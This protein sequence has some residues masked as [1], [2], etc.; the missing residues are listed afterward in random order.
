MKKLIASAL[1]AAFS[2]CAA[3]Q[4]TTVPAHITQVSTGWGYDSFSV[5]LS[6]P[7][8]N[9]AGCPLTDSASVS[10]DSSGY[11]TYYAAALTAFTNDFPVTLVISNTACEGSR[12]RIVGV[13]L[14]H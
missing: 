8:P 9:P 2:T 10:S 6:V 1:F 11:K 13:A 14:T 5:F 4:S 12:P 3:A 7:L